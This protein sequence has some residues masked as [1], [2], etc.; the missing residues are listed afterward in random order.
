MKF[1]LLLLPEI[2]NNWLLKKSVEKK[3]DD[4]VLARQMLSRYIGVRSRIKCF[5]GG[6]SLG[7]LL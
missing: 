2:L 6:L 3:R 1:K 4:R 5:Y 7:K